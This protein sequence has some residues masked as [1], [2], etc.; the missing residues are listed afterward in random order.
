MKYFNF[1][2]ISDIFLFGLMGIVLGTAGVSIN[3]W[4]LYAI[5]LIAGI[6]S[7]RNG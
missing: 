6:L 7:A 1:V 5:M 3:N 4:Q 2:S